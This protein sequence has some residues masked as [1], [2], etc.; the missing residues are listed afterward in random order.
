MAKQNKYQYVIYKGYIHKIPIS[1]KSEEREN[2]FDK[3]TKKKKEN[4]N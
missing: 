4:K 1:K 2:T 3:K